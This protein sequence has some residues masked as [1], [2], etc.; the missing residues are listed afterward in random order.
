MAR[1]SS[2]SRADRK[3]DRAKEQ[4][5][6]ELQKIVAVKSD[7]FTS[8]DRLLTGAAHHFELVAKLQSEN[9]VSS[10]RKLRELR[11]IKYDTDPEPSS[12][13][14]YDVQAAKGKVSKRAVIG[15]DGKHQRIMK[16]QTARN[17][18]AKGL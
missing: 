8:Y 13:G 18:Q 14:M 10:R 2:V 16:G 5:A 12:D 17:N 11:D 6:T 3:A 1:H 9:S 7:R 15:R 4:I